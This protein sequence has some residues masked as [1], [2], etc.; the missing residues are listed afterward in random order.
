MPATRRTASIPVDEARA[1]LTDALDRFEQGL[2]PHNAGEWPELTPQ[3]RDA[4][5]DVRQLAWADTVEGPRTRGRPDLPSHWPR[6]ACEGCAGYGWYWIDPDMSAKGWSPCR[7]C[8]ATGLTL[9]LGD[10]AV[11]AAL[12]ISRP[13]RKTAGTTRG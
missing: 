2:P 10:T 6:Q 4:L 13:K 8:L 11:A 7:R 9:K 3:L 1:R 5:R 12:E